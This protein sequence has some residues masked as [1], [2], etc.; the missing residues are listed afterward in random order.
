MEQAS[1]LVGDS[2]GGV[3]QRRRLRPMP[4]QFT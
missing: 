4:Q 3:S 1:G 2:S